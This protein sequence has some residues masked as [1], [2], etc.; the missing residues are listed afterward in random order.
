MEIL[1][2]YLDQIEK[3]AIKEDVS[4]TLR[5]LIS[6]ASKLASGRKQWRIKQQF[7][8]RNLNLPESVKLNLYQRLHKNTYV[9]S[10]DL[11][12]GAQKD[13]SKYFVG[14]PSRSATAKGF[15]TRIKS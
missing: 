10:N 8:F 2:S 3:L 14:T 1:T 6:K 4:D 12:S 11:S 5:T 15:N 7:S 13:Y 9:L